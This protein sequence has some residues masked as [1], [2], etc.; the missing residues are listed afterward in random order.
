M[1]Y[2]YILQNELGTLYTGFSMYLRRRILEHNRGKSF[3]TKNHRW[4]LIYYEAGLNE[5]DARR[6]ERYFKT[7]AGR[8]SLRLRLREHLS[9]YATRQLRVH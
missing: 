9:L 6:R 7:T 3:S 4:R 1:F 2:V 5:T 8:R